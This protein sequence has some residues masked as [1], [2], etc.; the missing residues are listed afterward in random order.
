MPRVGGEGAATAAADKETA[1]ED[2]A[3]LDMAE[4]TAG[5]RRRGRG[6][7]VYICP[8]YLKS[9][10]MKLRRPRHAF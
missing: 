5:R 7:D 9:M 2:A 3:P 10:K 6:Q 8:M 1:A 4:Q